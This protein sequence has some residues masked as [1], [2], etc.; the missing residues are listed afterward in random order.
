[1]IMRKSVYLLA[2]VL[3][4]W[5]QGVRASGDMEVRIIHETDTT[6]NYD[7]NG[8]RFYS[9][10]VHRIDIAYATTDPEGNPA[11]MSGSIA[12][13][14]DVYEGQQPC[15]G[16]VLFSHDMLILPHEA[17]TCGMTLGEEMFL[18]NERQPN[19]IVVAPDY[20]GYG[21]TAGKEPWFCHG[22]V[23]AQSGIDCLLAAR[24]L[25]SGRSIPQ[26]KYLANAGYSSGAYEAL[27]VQKLRDM[28]YRDQFS[29]DRTIVGGVPFG[30][31]VAYNELI[32]MKDKPGQHLWFLMLMDNYN[33]H[34]NLG[35][36]PQQMMKAPWDEEFYRWKNGSYTTAEFLDKL[37]GRTLS[38]LVQDDL[39]DYESPTRDMLREPM[40][41]HEL[42][43]GW[44]PDSTQ[45]Y[46]V[47]H[48]FRDRTIPVWSARTFHYILSDYQYED[49]ENYWSSALFKRSIIPEKTHMNTNF[50]KATSDHVLAGRIA[51][52]RSLT[53]LLS[54]LPV[55]YYDGELNT[56]YSDV[57][58]NLTPLGVIQKLESMGVPFRYI[59]SG[60]N[61]SGDGLNDTLASL[62]LTPADLLDI[63]SDC[64]IFYDDLV[65]ILNYLGIQIEE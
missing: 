40:Y 42:E 43:T 13:P 27:A 14:S 11:E 1:M 54:A 51:Y 16:M 62:D 30:V 35:F 5:V 61:G 17:P 32:G 46:T 48:S 60:F 3:L 39:L 9:R 57:I 29:F 20:Y 47:I 15:D 28:K 41:D 25:L 59:L 45:N 7:Y 21:I 10:P 52:F 58:N 34:L 50:L 12:I 23:N 31:G 55:L 36:T 4:A 38:E 63:A 65:E 49:G 6:W 18:A 64:G 22:D 56:Y 8:F 53:G 19:Y 37:N 44:E 24:Q 2:V 26:G 33:T